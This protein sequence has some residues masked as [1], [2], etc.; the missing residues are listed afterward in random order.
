MLKGSKE[1]ILPR[2]ISWLTSR[3][4][5]FP[6]ILC[7]FC[8]GGTQKIKFT[9][10]FCIAIYWEI[11]PRKHSCKIF[12]DDTVTCKYSSKI[13]YNKIVFM[14]YFLLKIMAYY[15]TLNYRKAQIMYIHIYIKYIYTY[16]YVKQIIYMLYMHT[17]IYIYL[18]GCV[19]LCIHT[20]IDIYIYNI[21][22][23]CHQIPKD[24]DYS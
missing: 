11:L 22:V 2:K 8:S 5:I 13:K 23:H 9:T 17:I 15:K 10:T 3:N 1:Q 4:S 20:P 19:C 16:T 6:I 24:W 21:V 12:Y 7:C 14:M 18:W